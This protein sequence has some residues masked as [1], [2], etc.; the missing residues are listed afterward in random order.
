MRVTTIGIGVLALLMAAP[1]F[2]QDGGT[3]SGT[4]VL[5]IAEL[6]LGAIGTAAVPTALALWGLFKA[7]AAQSEAAWD[8]WMVAAVE[9]VAR[10]IAADE[11]ARTPAGAAIE[12]LDLRGKLGGGS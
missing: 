4:V 9:K 7:H 3:D 5:S 1:A 2:A 12:P 11:I 10:E 6:V 8:D